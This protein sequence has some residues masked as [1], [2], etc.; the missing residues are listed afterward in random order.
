MLTIDLDDFAV[1]LEEG[2]VK[3][4]GAPTTGAT[5][6]LYHVEEAGARAFGDS[7]VKLGFE[8]GEGNEVEVALDPEQ[9]LAVAR[10]L[11]DLREEGTVFE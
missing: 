7:Q 2:T 8:D 5:V 1:E 4:V 10:D 9:A 3:H 6:K 11:E